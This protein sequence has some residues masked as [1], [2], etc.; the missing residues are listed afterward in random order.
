[1]K[2]DSDLDSK[3]KNLQEYPDLEDS[4]KNLQELCMDI[5]TFYSEKDMQKYFSLSFILI[6]RQNKKEK[7]VE[8]LKNL[9]SVLE[10]PQIPK[11]IV[12]KT[13]DAYKILTSNILD[14][15][16]KPIGSL[17]GYIFDEVI[18]AEEIKRPSEEQ[19]EEAIKE[20]IQDI[21]KYTKPEIETPIQKH[22]PPKPKHVIEKKEPEPVKKHYEKRLKPIKKEKKEKVKKVKAKKKKTRKTTKRIMGLAIPLG[23]LTAGIITT[24]SLYYTQK[25]KIDSINQ[26]IAET[27]KI[28]QYTVEKGKIKELAKKLSGQTLYAKDL[29]AIIQD[30]TDIKSGKYKLNDLIS[31]D[32][33][34]FEEDIN[35][36][37]E[38]T[39]INVKKRKKPLNQPLGAPVI[40]AAGYGVVGRIIWGGID[41]KPHGG[42]D[43]CSKDPNIYAAGDGIVVKVKNKYKKWKGYGK[44]LDIR[45]HYGDVEFITRYGH[46][47]NISVS[48]GDSVNLGD[49]IAELGRTGRATGVHLH[50]EVRKKWGHVNPGPYYEKITACQVKENNSNAYQIYKRLN[51][52]QATVNK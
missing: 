9:K 32:D 13:Y 26:E 42:I 51:N 47:K 10:D 50:F 35:E 11:E 38:N 19:P 29:I 33:H 45:H 49:K 18:R 25:N 37:F 43:F 30:S 48:V 6:G 2:A 8:K 22:E 28:C 14:E 3:L 46:C 44:F 4:L 31:C 16:T 41:N 24:A 34:Y 52:E 1:M 12:D 5:A 23:V 39:E 17:R 27:Q 40:F 15:E 21:T 36:Y 20:Q 7:L